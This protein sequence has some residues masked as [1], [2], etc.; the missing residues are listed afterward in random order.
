MSSKKWQN[1]NKIIER[2]IKACGFKTAKELADYLEVDPTTISTWKK[3]NSIDL[4]VLLAKCEHINYNWLLTGEGEMFK[5]ER[6]EAFKQDKAPFKRSL[7]GDTEELIAFGKAI[8]GNEYGWQ[9]R[10]AKELGYSKQQLSNIINGN[11]PIG[12]SVREKVRAAAKKHGKPIESWMENEELIKSEHS[13]RK[14]EEPPQKEESSISSIK[15]KMTELEKRAVAAEAQVALLKEM[16]YKLTADYKE[17][18]MAKGIEPE[19][20]TKRRPMG[21]HA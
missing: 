18:A 17:I 7:N 8:V 20:E 9:T 14:T 3:R 13:G 21:A 2:A 15:N 12:S 4:D 19:G 11:A 1:A 5:N 16:Y 6:K 10:F